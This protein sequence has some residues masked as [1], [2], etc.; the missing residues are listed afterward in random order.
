MIS[1]AAAKSLTSEHLND[2]SKILDPR[3]KASPGRFTTYGKKYKIDSMELAWTASISS[4][5]IRFNPP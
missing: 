1:D 4:S 5:R 2:L 3:M